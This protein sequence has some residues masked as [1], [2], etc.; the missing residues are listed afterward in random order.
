MT[1]AKA[2]ALIAVAIMAAYCGIL[3]APFIFDDRGSILEN[4]SIRHLAETGQA[5]GD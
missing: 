4:P 5:E 3:R 2:A 1:K